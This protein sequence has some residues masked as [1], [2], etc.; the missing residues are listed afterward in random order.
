MVVPT[1]GRNQNP[2]QIVEQIHEPIPYCTLYAGERISDVD[3]PTQLPPPIGHSRRS[4]L[5]KAVR[6]R[7]SRS[8]TNATEV[9]PVSSVERKQ[10]DAA[11]LESRFE[12]QQEAAISYVIKAERQPILF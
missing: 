10:N 4:R 2:G 7:Q 1:S 12:C 3:Q 6:G 5:W 8:Y 11:F 9:A